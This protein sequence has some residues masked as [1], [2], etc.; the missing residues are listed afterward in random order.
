MGSRKLTSQ[1]RVG[2]NFSMSPRGQG[3]LKTRLVV[4]LSFCAQAPSFGLR[5]AAPD[6]RTRVASRH[7]LPDRCRR[8]RSPPPI[9]SVRSSGSRCADECCKVSEQLLGGRAKLVLRLAERR[10]VAQLGFGRLA[11][12]PKRETACCSEGFS[13]VIGRADELGLKVRTW[14]AARRARSPALL[15]W[16]RRA[17]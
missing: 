4:V 9:R 15:H 2:A 10:G 14:L 11:D 12:W 8:A 16:P 6:R 1:N 3:P 17:A 7:G 5:H 13:G